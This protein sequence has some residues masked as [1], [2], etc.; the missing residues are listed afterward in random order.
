LVSDVHWYVWNHNYLFSDGMILTD[1]LSG[2][3][4]DL[5]L[6]GHV[7]RVG[8]GG[9]SSA[10]AEHENTPTEYIYT[11]KIFSIG[12]NDDRVSQKGL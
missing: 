11:H 10:D 3:V 2:C 1:L 8:G 12:Y 6:W 7:G 4:D 9:E 5:P